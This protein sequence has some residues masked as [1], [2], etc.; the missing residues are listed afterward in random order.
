AVV[1]WL[2]FAGLVDLPVR[3]FSGHLT[4]LEAAPMLAAQGIWWLAL[5]GLGRVLLQ[6]GV[7][8]LVIQGG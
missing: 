6:R 7:R 3:L 1:V 2:P 5:V 8:R 4:A